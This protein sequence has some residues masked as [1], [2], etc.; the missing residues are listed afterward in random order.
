MVP[1][2]PEGPWL[3]HS[4][5]GHPEAPPHSVNRAG[6]SALQSPGIFWRR[7]RKVLCLSPSPSPVLDLLQAT[8]SSV[9]RSHHTL[10]LQVSPHSRMRRKTMFP[11]PL[12]FRGH[13]W[14]KAPGPCSYLH[15][16]CEPL[17][18]HQ[19][20]ADLQHVCNNKNGGRGLLHS[21]GL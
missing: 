20:D 9:S 11:P 21:W 15:T 14:V 4:P 18:P 10:P 3:P 19:P 17:T 13:T 2:P 1:D 12:I 7:A 6:H 5:L 8:C 16:R